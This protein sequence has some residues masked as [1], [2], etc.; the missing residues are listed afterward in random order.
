LRIELKQNRIVVVLTEAETSFLSHKA[1][2]AGQKDVI[3]FIKAKLLKTLELKGF[4]DGNIVSLANNFNLAKIK[5][6]STELSKRKTLPDTY[7]PEESEETEENIAGIQ[8]FN[9]LLA[10]LLDEEPMEEIQEMVEIQNP[11][12]EKIKDPVIDDLLADLLDKDLVDGSKKS[13]NSDKHT[14]KSRKAHPKGQKTED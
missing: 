3:S 9:D 4:E 1:A 7:L 14:L 5:H 11:K 2:S 13:K 12:S 6:V 10:N 8:D